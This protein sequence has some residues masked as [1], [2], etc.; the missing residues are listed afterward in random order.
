MALT[1][2]RWEQARR[3]LTS[4]ALRAYIME[5]EPRPDAR[6][7]AVSSQQEAAVSSVQDCVSPKTQAC[8]KHGSTAHGSAAA[9]ACTT[10][11]TDCCAGANRHAR[12]RARGAAIDLSTRNGWPRVGARGAPTPNEY[13]RHFP[14][15]EIWGKI[16]LQPM[17][18]KMHFDL[19]ESFPIASFPL[20]SIAIMNQRA[21]L[22]CT[23]QKSQSAKH[24]SQNFLV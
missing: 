5:R 18:P 20:Q 15:R 14:V 3:Q 24:F 13:L 19:R 7:A 11:S 23:T 4:A 17:H 10:R 16:L 12:R 8:T 22:D 1:D 9:R 21:R 2:G 6:S